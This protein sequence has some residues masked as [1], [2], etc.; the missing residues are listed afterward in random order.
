MDHADYGYTCFSF[1]RL[2]GNIHIHRWL[3][4]ACWGLRVRGGGRRGPSWPWLGGVG[5]VGMVGRYTLVAQ[6]IKR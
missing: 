5:M 3:L 1:P 2:E 4:L 6:Y